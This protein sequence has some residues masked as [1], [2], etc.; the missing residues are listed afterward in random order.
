MGST[1]RAPSARRLTPG[2]ESQSP[3]RSHRSL[4]VVSSS[5]SV[6]LPQVALRDIT[7]LAG[8]TSEKT[9]VPDSESLTQIP[10]SPSRSVSL[11]PP[12]RGPF[13]SSPWTSMSTETD[14]LEAV[15]HGYDPDPLTTLAP[16]PRR[17]FSTCVTAR[18]QLARLLPIEA[19]QRSRGSAW[20]RLRHGGGAN[21][22]VGCQNPNLRCSTK[23]TN[24][25]GLPPLRVRIRDPQ[26][27][28]ALERYSRVA[29]GYLTA[30]RPNR[31]GR[32]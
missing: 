26:S 10:K 25:G 14:P 15:S 19:P 13:P 21:P 23:G 22:W 32:S 9:G 17:K 31:R 2:D 30:Q 3:S 24:V 29:S 4:K 11:F 20:A 12:S 6:Q 8:I 18:S 27:W 1:V 16:L 28:I 5:T 7:W